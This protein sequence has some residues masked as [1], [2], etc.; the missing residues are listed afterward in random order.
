MIPFTTNTEK[1]KK[2]AY[3]DCVYAW[4]LAHS[5]EDKKEYHCYIY[6][7]SFTFEKIGKDINRTRQTVGKRFKE[8]IDANLI[9]EKK[10]CGKTAFLMPYSNPFEYIDTETAVKLLALPLKEQKEE[11]IKTLSYILKKKTQANLEK[12]SNF[13]ITSKEI[14]EEF[15][16]SIGNE[17]SYQRIR[18]NLTV[19]QGAGIIKFKTINYNDQKGMPPVMVVYQVNST[20]R[21]SDEWLGGGEAEEKEDAA[22]Q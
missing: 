4:L 1:Y 2:L 18:M 9:V 6:K 5:Y 11:L 16:H 14:L 3:N 22:A 8:L 19:L 20:G 17:Q 12:K 13:T 15:G 7:E 10:V 21:A